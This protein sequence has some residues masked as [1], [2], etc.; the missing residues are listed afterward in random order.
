M[1]GMALGD[2]VGACVEFRPHNF[3]KHHPVTTLKGGGTWGLKTGQ[4]ISFS[5]YIYVALKRC[6]TYLQ[7]E[8]VVCP[9]F[10]SLVLKITAEDYL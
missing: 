2:A 6:S 7:R 5:R 1:I 4:V 3:L 8:F 9:Y 10:R